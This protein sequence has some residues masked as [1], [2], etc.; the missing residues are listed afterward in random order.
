VLSHGARILLIDLQWGNV[1]VD[2]GCLNMSVPHQP[3]E[4]RKA[5]A[6]AQ[7]IGGKGVT[8]MPSSA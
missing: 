1:H 8:A 5:D 7:H 6:G 3:H 4:S 2:E